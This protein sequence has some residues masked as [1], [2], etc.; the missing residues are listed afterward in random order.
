M[1]KREGMTVSPARIAV[2]SATGNPIE[3]VC[4]YATFRAPGV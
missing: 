2:A 3:G 4:E 1:P